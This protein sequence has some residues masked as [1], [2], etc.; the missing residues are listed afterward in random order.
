MQQI[1]KL[2]QELLVMEEEA[3]K[4][5][6]ATYLANLRKGEPVW[7]ILVGPPSSGRTEL[8]KILQGCP[9][10]RFLSTLTEKTFLSGL[11]KSKSGLL[12]ELRSPAVIAIKDLSTIRSLPSTKEQEILAQL[13]EIYD[14]MFI[15]RWGTGKEIKWKGKLG[16]IAAA[17]PD[18]ENDKT[19]NTFL[20]ERFLYYC[21]LEKDPIEVAKK[22]IE[23]DNPEILRKEI[24][25]AVQNFC[26]SLDLKQ[27]ISFDPVVK[28]KTVRLACF[29]A[30]LRTPVVRDSRTREV[31]K[32]CESEYPAR[33]LKALTI[34]GEALALVSG[35]SSVEEE[36]YRILFKVAID[37]APKVRVDVLDNLLQ[38]KKTIIELAKELRVSK[39]TV[40]RVV[41]ELELLG[42]VEE[43][44]HVKPFIGSKGSGRPA[45]HYNICHS[46][47]KT[48]EEI[49]PEVNHASKAI[50]TL[51][52]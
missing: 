25:R 52:P 6:L 51:T 48:L 46:C 41:E 45:T 13:R 26:S 33:M 9:K 27:S 28:N 18:I 44:P 24:I 30:E 11:D 35:R 7:L 5:V 36:D 23:V 8:I 3:I 31:S 4:L 49:S 42:F 16:I 34:L 50:A 17:T 1:L 29:I 2:V 15:K 12:E 32:V 10:V 37:T 21:L 14:G 38:G 40:R 20:G 47:I 19:L 39:S 43:S 22:S